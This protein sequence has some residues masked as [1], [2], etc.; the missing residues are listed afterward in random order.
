M[1]WNV[2][3]VN[4][5]DVACWS[6]TE[7]SGVGRAAIFVDIGGKN[8]FGC[9]AVFTRKIL[10]RLAKTADS[11]EK[12]D[13]FES[14]RAEAI[15]AV[16]HWVFFRKPGRRIQDKVR[17]TDRFCVPTKGGKLIA[18]HRWKSS[19]WLPRFSGEIFLCCTNLYKVGQKLYK[20][21]F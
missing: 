21:G 6:V 17:G 12:V 15:G 19:Q 14:L 3:L 7:I 10:H 11:A 5:F 8:A 9:D 4:F 16:L 13:K 20:D 1:R 2:F 18:D